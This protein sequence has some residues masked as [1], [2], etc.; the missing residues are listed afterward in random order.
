MASSVQRSRQTVPQAFT[1][2]GARVGSNGS[3]QDLPTA[4]QRLER[5]QSSSQQTELLERPVFVVPKAATVS[6]LQRMEARDSGR[7]GGAGDGNAARAALS[8]HSVQRQ[9]V[10][11]PVLSKATLANNNATGGAQ[12]LPSTGESTLKAG[13][14]RRRIVKDGINAGAPHDATESSKERSSGVK[15]NGSSRRNSSVTGGN[16]PSRIKVV[17]RSGARGP[18]SQ[19]KPLGM[20]GEKGFSSGNPHHW[21]SSAM[22]SPS[23]T[24][25]T[26]SGDCSARLSI[27]EVSDVLSPMTPANRAYYKTLQTQQRQMRSGGWIGAGN[28]GAGDDEPTD[29]D[30]PVDFVVEDAAPDYIV[31]GG[32]GK[33]NYGG[34]AS[35][36]G[37]DFLFNAV[38]LNGDTLQHQNHAPWAASRAP[39]QGEALASGTTATQQTGEA[40]RLT[41]MGNMGSDPVGARADFDSSRGV[42]KERAKLSSEVKRHNGLPMAKVPPLALDT[43]NANRKTV[44]ATYKV[45]HPKPGMVVPDI[46]SS[47][48]EFSETVNNSSLP[49]NSEAPDVTVSSTT[50]AVSN[51]SRGGLNEGSGEDKGVGVGHNGLRLADRGA[52]GTRTGVAGPSAPKGGPKNYGRPGMSSI[53]LNDTR[54]G[55]QDRGA[56]SSWNGRGSFGRNA[57]GFQMNAGPAGSTERQRR[58]EGANGRGSRNA[59]HKA[60]SANKQ[61]K[62]CLVM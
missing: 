43:I 19:Y 60:T 59:R 27:Q 41:T 11:A 57:G 6:L 15:V 62:C 12:R 53:P 54:N 17:S 4:A 25:M 10:R 2:A 35:K 24:T 5:T 30:S 28:R 40:V 36:P 16:A 32:A 26:V 3:S 13:A 29:G 23:R 44:K 56:S 37:F 45:S 38:T 51:L 20:W 61:T 7:V 58:S 18:A 49:V 21:T 22:L 47:S 52:N 34:Q 14:Q 48:T 9:R 50:D 31:P 8:Q 42:S 46:E 33:G 39:T 55:S 1:N